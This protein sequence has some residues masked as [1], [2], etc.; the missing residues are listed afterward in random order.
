MITII[1][2]LILAAV[3]ISLVVGQG[4]L[5]QRTRNSTSLYKEKTDEELGILNSYSDQIDAETGLSV[6][7]KIEHNR[8][9]GLVI[10]KNGKLYSFIPE[11][12]DWN[13][14]FELTFVEKNIID[15]FKLYD[16]GDLGY[17]TESGNLVIEGKEIANNV[18]EIYNKSNYCGYLT[19]S[20][21]LYNLS[22]DLKTRTYKTERTIDNVKEAFADFAGHLYLT[23]DN[24]LCMS[25]YNQEE[26][27]YELNEIADNVNEIYIFENQYYYLTNSNKLFEFYFDETSNEYKSDEIDNNVKEVIN[28][29]RFSGYL[30]N[31]YKLYKYNYYKKF[32]KVSDIGK[33]IK[34]V[35][36][37]E[38]PFYITIDNELYEINYNSSKDKYET[39]KIADN[40]KEIYD[41]RGPFLLTTSNKLCTFKYDSTT[42]TYKIENV[43]D[44]VKE[45][46]MGDDVY[47]TNNNELYELYYDSET[48]KY[49][50]NKLTDN[51]TEYYFPKHYSHYGAFACTKDD[52]MRT[53]IA[54]LDY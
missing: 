29:S 30:T 52:I 10:L 8:Y 22:Y 26:E 1:I 15:I 44:N 24:K 48:Q 53:G 45:L 7:P 39:I 3:T 36:D 14:D 35:C 5:I 25:F 32:V 40:V 27:K 11:V 41:Y 23:N 38:G 28:T 19:N 47:L 17:I 46:Y 21:E 18:K 4:G 54:S 12:S 2:L 37:N 20:S 49:E 13:V 42:S 6:T 51:V 43:V 34:D 16:S 9:S 31:D 33:D 50:F